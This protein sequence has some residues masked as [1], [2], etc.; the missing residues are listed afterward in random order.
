M[1]EYREREFGTPYKRFMDLE[2]GDNLYFINLENIHIEVGRVRTVDVQDT[3]NS[4]ARNRTSVEY[5]IEVKNESDKSEVFKIYDGNS[6]I[7]GY[8]LSNNNILVCTDERI[9]NSI[10]DALRS[11][12]NIQWKKFTSIF[13]NPMGGYAAKDIVLRNCGQQHARLEAERK[14]TEKTNSIDNIYPAAKEQYEWNEEK[15]ELNKIESKPAWSENDEM[16]L[17]YIIDCCKD[18]IESNSKGLEL[19]KDT[20]KSLFAWLKSLKER[21]QLQPQPKQELSEDAATDEY[22]ELGL[23]SGT[24]WKFVNEKGYYAFDEAIVKFGGGNIPN[25]EQWEELN[26]KCKWVWKEIG[27]EVTGPNGNTIYL[28]ANGYRYGNGTGLLNVGTY[29]Y[30]WSSTH[31]NEAG[32]YYMGFSDPVA[33]VNNGPCF[34]GLSV[35]LVK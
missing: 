30:Y 1:L 17:R 26:E 14:P 35:R 2:V 8:S 32:A 24:L 3:S 4:F 31:H 7:D 12:N 16:L 29:G 6:F 5:S 28:P 20:T 18:T 22:I 21:V 10:V 9:S 13:G 23:P 27:Y 15:K 11:R 34:C 19:S 25:K 33:G